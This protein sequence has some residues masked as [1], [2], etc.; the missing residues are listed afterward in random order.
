MSLTRLKFPNLNKKTIKS[1]LFFVG[2]VIII[3]L[4]S[5]LPF[6]HPVVQKAQGG[7]VNIGTSINQKIFSGQQSE[8]DWKSRAQ[9]AETLA[10]N[11]AISQTELTDLRSQV[12]ELQKL[13]SYVQETNTPGQLA[14]V[15]ARSV[16]DEGTILINLGAEDGLRSGMAV[17][18]EGGHLIGVVET[19]NTDSSVVRLSTDDQSR[20][21]ASVYS[22]ARTVGLIEGQDGFLLS[23]NFVT[24]DQELTPGQIVATSGLDG[25]LPAGLII[26]VIDSV[27]KEERAPFQSALVRPLF[28]SQFYSYVYVFDPLKR[29]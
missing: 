8:D 24:Q 7:F 18:V 3:F 9:T 16:S 28:D 25:S 2:S 20:I 1:S 23:L 4:L 5:Q 15:L 29:S 6:V 26:G 22:D 10:G 14:R 11:L 19:V 21:P 17:I 12:A 27:V 13:F